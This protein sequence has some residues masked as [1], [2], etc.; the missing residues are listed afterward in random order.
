MYSSNA[1]E[2]NIS[3]EVKAS[4]KALK[5]KVDRYSLEQI[6]SNLIS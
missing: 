2:K 4:S 5:V 6:L 1:D 3:I